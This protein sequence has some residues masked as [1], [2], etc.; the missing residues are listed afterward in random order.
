MTVRKPVKP[1]ESV[2]IK[3]DVQDDQAVKPSSWSIERIEKDP[4]KEILLQKTIMTGYFII[5]FIHLSWL[6]K[7]NWNI[8][9]KRQTAKMKPR[10][11][12]NDWCGAGQQSPRSTIQ[13]RRG[14][15]GI[16]FIFIKSNVW[17]EKSIELRIDGKRNQQVS[18]ALEADPY[19]AFDVKGTNLYFKMVCL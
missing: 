17:S 12:K 15:Y 16:R 10:R 19:I 3:A 11:W 18:S 14:R 6:G 4:F 9:L 7:N 8:S 2:E 1:T 5:L 13:C